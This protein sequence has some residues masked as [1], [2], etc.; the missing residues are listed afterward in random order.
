M[1]EYSSCKVIH[2]LVSPNHDPLSPLMLVCHRQPA[3]PWHG[4]GQSIAAGAVASGAFTLA[5]HAHAPPTPPSSAPQNPAWANYPQVSAP[6]A[7]EHY[8]HAH[9]GHYEEEGDEE[10]EDD[11][12]DDEGGMYNMFDD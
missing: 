11:D 10:E 7:P 5:A 1:I 9:A 6:P 12:D 4:A 2:P 8:E 3:L